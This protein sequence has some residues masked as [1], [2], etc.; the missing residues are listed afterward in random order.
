V[1]RHLFLNKEHPYI[2]NWLLVALIPGAAPLPT[3]L[4][5]PALRLGQLLPLCANDT[6]A[7]LFLVEFTETFQSHNRT[8]TIGISQY[9]TIVLKSFTCAVIYHLHTR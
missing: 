3:S 7:R 8:S 9:S 1:S 6:G 4:F 2:P 5:R